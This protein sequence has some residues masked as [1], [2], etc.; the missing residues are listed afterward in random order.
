MLCDFHSSIKEV[1]VLAFTSREHIHRTQCTT[2]SAEVAQGYIKL[3]PAF[4]TFP[5]ERKADKKSVVSEEQ[6]HKFARCFDDE[7]P[8]HALFY[9]LLLA[10][11]IKRAECVGLKWSDVNLIVAKSP[12]IELWYPCRMSRFL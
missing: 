7:L 3:N 2:L 4:R 9:K 1:A 10:T 11:G 12:Q 8:K 5:Y 6:L